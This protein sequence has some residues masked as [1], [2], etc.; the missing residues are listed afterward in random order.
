[1]DLQ[2]FEW[3]CNL[4]WILHQGMPNDV[5]LHIFLIQL[6]VHFCCSCSSLWIV[7]AGLFFSLWNKTSCYI[8]EWLW[9]KYNNIFSWKGVSGLLDGIGCEMRR[10]CLLHPVNV[11]PA[12]DNNDLILN[13]SVNCLQCQIMVDTVA[14]NMNHI[15]LLGLC[16][17]VWCKQDKLQVCSL[18]DSFFYVSFLLK[19]IPEWIIKSMIAYLIFAM[20]VME[21]LPQKTISKQ[22][23][24]HIRVINIDSIQEL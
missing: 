19:N 16:H 6:C 21:L 12:E 22:K 7:N 8:L 10:I 24:R 23:R 9:S 4:H 5:K 14:V 13:E 20:F 11:G 15:F 1:M 3:Q 18:Q 2:I 17:H